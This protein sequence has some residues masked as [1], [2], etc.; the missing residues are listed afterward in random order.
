M[1]YFLVETSGLSL[2][3]TNDLELNVTC[4]I[5]E[6]SCTNLSLSIVNYEL[7]GTCEFDSCVSGCCCSME[8]M[9]V[10]GDKLYA[11]VFKDGQR[12]HSQTIDA[13]ET[14]KPKAPYIDK[15][16]SSNGIYGIQWRTNMNDKAIRSELEGIVTCR[17]KEDDTKIVKSVQPSTFEEDKNYS[18]IPGEKLE[19]SSTYVISVRTRTKFGVVSDSSNEIIFTTDSSTNGGLIA[20]ILC[21]SVFAIVVSGVAFVSFFKLKGKLWDTAAK[22]EKPDLLDFK[23]NKIVILT[24]ESLSVNSLSVEPLVSKVSLTLSK[25]SL[26]DS[27]DRS[28][29]TSGISTAS[30]SLGYAN[31]EP[32]NIEESVLEALK[33]AFP[34]FTPAEDTFS[35]D[36]P[37]QSSVLTPPVEK[38][39]SIVVFDNKSYLSTEITP[40]EDVDLQMSCDM[41]YHSSTGPMLHDFI[42]PAHVSA[43]METD[44]SYRPCT[45]AEEASSDPQNLLTV[46]YGYQEFEKLVE[47]SNN[48]SSG[49]KAEECESVMDQSHC[50]MIPH[51]TNDIIVDHGYHC[52]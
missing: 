46:V 5:D 17:K 24:P 26:S 48:V 38:T 16:S 36:G 43:V 7:N 4:N 23:P 14:V 42:I 3:C 13:Y 19:P 30:S 37:I 41:G 39:S 22:E 1:E 29:Q 49:E 2:N 45:H 15:F 33:N 34:N 18:E 32:L 8:I 52:A 28:G 20:L 47:Q 10:Y 44:M 6:N 31:A 40:T 12:I 11:N 21:L 27:S 25:E 51:A 35:F 50:V 9:V